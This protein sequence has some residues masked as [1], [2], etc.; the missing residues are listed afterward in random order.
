L[1]TTPCC[2]AREVKS[3]GGFRDVADSVDPAPAVKMQAAIILT[4]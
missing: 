4:A 1:N 2:F 3:P